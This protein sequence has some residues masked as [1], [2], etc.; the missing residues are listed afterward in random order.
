M[1]I[2][3]DAGLDVERVAQH[4]IR[5]LSGD[6]RQLKQ[7]VHPARDLSVE[8][9]DDDLTGELDVLGLI[10]V[11]IHAGN[12]VLECGEI[13]RCIILDAFVFFEEVSGYFVHQHIGALS[14]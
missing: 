5:R 4:D 10:P 6:S 14:R 13:S 7:L 2:H 1:R 3:N 8:P 9:L 11:K 12:V